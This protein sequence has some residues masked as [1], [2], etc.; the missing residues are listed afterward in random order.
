MIQDRQSGQNKTKINEFLRD[1]KSE[2]Q[3]YKKKRNKPK[4][5]FQNWKSKIARER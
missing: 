4:V 5:E 2:K 1:W 3:F